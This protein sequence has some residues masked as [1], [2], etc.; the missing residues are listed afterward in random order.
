[1]FLK[2]ITVILLS[3]LFLFSNVSA[4]APKIVQFK[5]PSESIRPYLFNPA[6]SFAYSQGR[7]AQLEVAINKSAPSISFNGE[8]E[9]LLGSFI[10]SAGIRVI[11]LDGK[12]DFLIPLEN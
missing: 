11:S 12:E 8:N 7:F 3:S 9:H 4:A 6:Q 2:K 5:T 1:M 10:S